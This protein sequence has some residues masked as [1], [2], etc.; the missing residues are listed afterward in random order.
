MQSC[1]PKTINQTLHKRTLIVEQNFKLWQQL[2]L[3]VLLSLIWLQNFKE[4][5]IDIAKVILGK[6]DV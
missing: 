6:V 5:N 4:A 2:P 3:N 1:S